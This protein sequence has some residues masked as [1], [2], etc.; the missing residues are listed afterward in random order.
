MV[1]YRYDGS[2]ETKEVI[3]S[4]LWQIIRGDRMFIGLMGVDN[5]GKTMYTPSGN[6]IGVTLPWG[7]AWQ[8]QRIQHWI[9]RK[10][11]R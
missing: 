8:V 11:W 2:V 7:L 5:D 1:Q 3:L 4:T 10:T 9:A 6:R